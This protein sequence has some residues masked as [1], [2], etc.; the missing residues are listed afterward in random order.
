MSSPLSSPPPPPSAA[1]GT[2][3]PPPIPVFSHAPAG[4][5]IAVRNGTGTFTGTTSKSAASD[6]PAYGYTVQGSLDLNSFNETVNVVPTA[7]PPAGVTLPAG[8]TW[9]TFS[10]QGSN[11]VPSKGFLRVLVTP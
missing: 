6:V 2:V 3:S 4:S 11:G 7:V 5:P 9:K 8:Y 10:L 1:S